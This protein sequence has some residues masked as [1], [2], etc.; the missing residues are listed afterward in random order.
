MKA[1]HYRTPRTLADAEFRLG[2]A[3]VE[4]AHHRDRSAADWAMVALFA[5]FLALVGWGL[6]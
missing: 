5:L 2:H 3:E 1:S 4:H 6:A